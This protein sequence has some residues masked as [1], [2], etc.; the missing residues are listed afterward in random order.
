MNELVFRGRDR[1]RPSK[2]RLVFWLL[3]CAGQLASA[4]TKTGPASFRW[5]LG[6]MSVSVVLGFFV[7]VRCRT[8][9]GA[10]GITTSWGFGRGRTYPWHEIR[11]IDVRE[12]GTG[13]YETRTVRIT[14]RNRRRRSLP[15]LQRSYLYPAP[16]F[17]VAYR[18]VVNWWEFATNPADRFRPPLRKRDR[19]TPMVVGILLTVVV[20]LATGVAVFLGG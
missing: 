9:V 17:D 8:V 18:Q 2:G 13:L 16:D 10:S 5:M 19:L 7:T 12:T 11:W 3:L 4:Y 6:M 14:L 1:Y 15:A 20:I